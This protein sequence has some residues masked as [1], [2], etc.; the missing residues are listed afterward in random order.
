MLDNLPANVVAE[1]KIVHH[2]FFKKENISKMQLP[3][4]IDFEKAQAAQAQAIREEFLRNIRR[5]RNQQAE[6]PA[7][8][9][10]DEGPARNQDEDAG[11]VVD[12][13]E[14]ANAGQSSHQ[15]AFDEVSQD[16]YVFDE[17]KIKP[18]LEYEM[19]MENIQLN[20][21]W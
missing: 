1:F 7:M 12:E 15:H 2:P 19:M 14:W 13:A 4:V 20:H 6:E 11:L 5:N 17:F 8:N 18:N 21:Q 10:A 9:A 16:Q 3:S